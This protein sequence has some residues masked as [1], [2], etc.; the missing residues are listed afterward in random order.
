MFLLFFFTLFPF[1]DPLFFFLLIRFSDQGRVSVNHSLVPVSLP[2]P[3]TLVSAQTDVR[4]SAC[5]PEACWVSR[6]TVTLLALAQAI[7]RSLGSP[8]AHSFHHPPF[9]LDTV[10]CR[11][12]LSEYILHSLPLSSSS[13]DYDYRHQ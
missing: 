4:A 1:I 7:G 10:V 5:G 6:F 3:P 8:F 2:S 13:L 11:V 12:T 9:V